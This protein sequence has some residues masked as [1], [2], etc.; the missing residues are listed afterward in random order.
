M[1]A[2]F[3]SS[4]TS[5]SLQQE[6]E[7]EEPWRALLAASPTHA[8]LRTALATHPVPASM[9]TSIWMGFSGAADAQREGVYAVVL[10]RAMSVASADATQIDLD[11]SRSG[12]EG[13]AQ[14]A[15][16]RRVLRAF[17]TFRPDCG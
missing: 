12:Y 4:L 10:S 1:S 9:R 3:G 8:E 15:A 11:V 17:S 13:E 5:P 6:R 16:L 2:T 14:Q 7:E